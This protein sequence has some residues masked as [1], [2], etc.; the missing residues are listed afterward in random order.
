MN[1]TLN[2]VM[3]EPLASIQH[4][5]KSIWGNLISL[6]SGEKI[7]LNASSGK[8]KST[9]TLT[10]IGMRKD[11]NGTITYNDKD[12]KTFTP[13][14]WTDIR[15]KKVSVI[16][17]DLQLFPNLSVRENLLIKNS[18][19]DTFSE[20]EIKE[21]LG[22]L[23]IDDKWN[24]KG[25]LLS[26]GQQQRV[27]IIRALCQP[28]EWLIMDEPFSHLD[29]VNTAKCLELIDERTTKLGAGFVLT[30]LGDDHNFSYSRELNL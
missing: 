3:P 19:T 7:M 11:Y 5:E 4:G 17:Q 21:M 23:E 1:I 25:G 24:Q 28:Y 22:R 18:L 20:N 29:V 14:D 12:I 16:F 10:T 13:D 9:F 27:A 6:K 8:G 2:H 30:S 15:Q 26:M